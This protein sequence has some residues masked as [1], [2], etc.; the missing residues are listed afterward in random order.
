MLLQAEISSVLGEELS[1]VACISEHAFGE[2]Y[3][4]YDEQGVV[5]PLVAQVFHTPGLAAQIAQKYGVLS[6][7]SQIRL[8]LVH[9]LI[10]HQQLDL[11]DVLLIDRPGGVS[12]EVPCRMPER[13]HFLQEQIID[14][15]L[16]WHKQESSGLVGYVDSMQKN[17][18]QAWYQ[19]KITVLWSTLSR[20]RPAQLSLHDYQILYR[21]KA[22]LQSLLADAEETC[23]LVHGNLTLQHLLKDPRSDKLQA[24][25]C[26][27]NM[28]WAP[29]EF[30]LARLGH[31]PLSES[32]LFGY[33]QRFPVA[34]GFIARRWLYVLWEQVDQLLHSGHFSR[35]TFHH[36]AQSLF[37]WLNEG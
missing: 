4:L 2:I 14:A 29:R 26:P 12:A 20:L 31:D 35:E 32:I 15:L 36:A 22:H 5:I 17:S 34:E 30:E 37:P 7:H 19:Q 25:V 16:V 6:A 9:G 33:L 13:W 11:P 23:V 8:P 1:R 27:G 24:I 10:T 3:S 28:L 18:W 21:S